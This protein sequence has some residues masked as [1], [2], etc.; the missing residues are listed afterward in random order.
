LS[1]LTFSQGSLYGTTSAGGTH[2][3]GA[4][5]IMST[6]GIEG[7]LHSFNKHGDG[8]E[9]IGPLTIVPGPFV[10]FVGTTAKG[11]THNFGTIFS[12]NGAGAEGVVHS[13]DGHDGAYP[14]A[15]ILRL[16]G[17]FYGTTPNGGINSCASGCGTA[18]SFKP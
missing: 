13:F 18:F 17:M 5:F 12:L 16:G 7:L 1:R 11:G 2:G 4:I 6:T 9:P 14:S 3:Y 8:E 15:H 10:G